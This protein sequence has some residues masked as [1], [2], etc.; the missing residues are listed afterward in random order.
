MDRL[1]ELFEEALFTLQLT[2]S[3][4]ALLLLALNALQATGTLNPQGQETAV[5]LRQVALDN[6]RATST[7][8]MRS[9]GEMG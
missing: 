2:F 4:M 5:R 8:I 6:F 1:D 9:Q 3:E 7:E